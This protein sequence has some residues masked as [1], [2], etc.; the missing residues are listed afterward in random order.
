MQ[1]VTEEKVD[2]KREVTGRWGRRRCK[3]LLDDLKDKIEYW[4]L[5]EETLERALWRTCF[6]R[7]YGPIIR[8]PTIHT[9]DVLHKVGETS[10]CYLISNFE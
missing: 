6:G 1:H 5:K 10:G 4:K 7:G 2:G 3:W 8:Q 9:E